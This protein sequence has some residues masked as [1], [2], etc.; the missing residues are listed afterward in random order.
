M[1]IL[2]G[3]TLI[4]NSTSP[5]LSRDIR[6]IWQ[7]QDE[8][9]DMIA[10]FLRPQQG[11]IRLGDRILLDTVQGV[12]LPPEKRHVGVVFQDSFCFPI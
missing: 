8:H 2:P 6:T 9:L 4:S 11:M 5:N 1:A 10:G 12:S 3:S 7:R